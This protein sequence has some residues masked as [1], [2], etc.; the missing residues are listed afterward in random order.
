MTKTRLKVWVN[1]AMP[2]FVSFNTFVTMTMLTRID[3]QRRSSHSYILGLYI[4]KKEFTTLSD[5]LVQLSLFKLSTSRALEGWK[6][7]L[8]CFCTSQNHILR[9]YKNVLLQMNI[10]CELEYTMR[11]GTWH[12]SR[13]LDFR[14]GGPTYVQVW[15][16][17]GNSCEIGARER[18]G[19]LRQDV[20]HLRHRGSI[21][22]IYKL[23]DKPVHIPCLFTFQMH[24]SQ[25]KSKCKSKWRKKFATK[26]LIL[27]H[28]KQ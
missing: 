9:V 22:P 13:E 8:F 10:K 28:L 27:K 18:R 19:S 17:W 11:M 20:L 5:R 15:G 24:K 4:W 1:P 23:P 6:H 25:A 16:S 26:K 21:P 12:W 2:C 3:C 14:W 7:I